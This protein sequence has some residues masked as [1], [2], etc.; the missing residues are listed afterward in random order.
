MNE[1]EMRVVKIA[2]C[3]SLSGKSTLTYHI[4]CMDDRAIYLRLAENTGQ[5]NFSKDW[6]PLTLLDPLLESAD[7]PIT[8][9]LIRS[10]F[11]GKS[12]NTAGFFMAVLVA[13]GLLKVSEDVIRSY[14]P[15]DR[16]EFRS[17]IQ[18]LFDSGVSLAG[19]PASNEEQP[20][21]VKKAVLRKA[22]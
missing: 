13:E 17:G 2:T 11:D 22:H 19:S 15:R 10:L 16:T 3:P 7:T 1:K 9:S 18:S 5:G 8:A 6:I 21:Q 12:V 14:F 4:G 20:V